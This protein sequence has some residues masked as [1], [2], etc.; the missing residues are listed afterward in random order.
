[1]LP[2]C[3]LHN[4]VICY[5]SS[6]NVSNL[7]LLAFAERRSAI[8]QTCQ[9]DSLATRSREARRLEIGDARWRDNG[10]YGTLSPSGGERVMKGI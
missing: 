8:E 5:V 3:L 6:Q 9:D 10:F 7:R 4:R 1:M 2:Y